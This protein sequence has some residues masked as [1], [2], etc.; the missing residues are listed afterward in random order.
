M[1]ALVFGLDGTLVDTVYAHVIA[2]QC[3]LSEAGVAAGLPHYD[4]RDPLQNL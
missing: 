3:A 2:W 4:I 1:H